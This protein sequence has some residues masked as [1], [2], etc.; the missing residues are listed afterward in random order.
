MRAPTRPSRAQTGREF[1]AQHPPRL[2]KQRPVDGLVGHA[3]LRV[4]GVVDAQ[5]GTDLLGRPPRVQQRLHL[6][7]EP[8]AA[9]ELRGFRSARSRVGRLVSPTRSIPVGTAVTIDLAAHG[10]RSASKPPCNRSI[11]VPTLQATR[12]LFP[13]GQREL[14]RRPPGRPRRH[15]THGIQQPLDRLR[16][17]A[18]RSRRIL[19][20]TAPADQPTDRQ[21]LLSSQPLTPNSRVSHRN[22]LHGSLPCNCLSVAITT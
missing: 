7:A 14:P 1:L 3:H 11:R 2:H 13:L 20:T 21:P 6:R 8:W 5:S 10:R 17:T 9:S 4:V 19:E 12:D 16:R 22:T 15:A 18:D